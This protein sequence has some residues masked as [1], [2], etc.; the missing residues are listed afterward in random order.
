[1]ELERRGTQR[2]RRGNAEDVF[3]ELSETIIGCAVKVHSALGPGM[4][5]AAYE[6]C[7]C[8]ELARS[9]LSFRRQVPIPLVYEEVNLDCG[10]RL[11]LVV[12]H[13]AIV[14]LKSVD[15]LLPI[16]DCQLLTYLR[17]SGLHLGILL[18]FNVA[19]LR[20]GIRRKVLM[21]P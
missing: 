10:F 4:L 2:I 16:H 12:E 21:I 13:K 17:A 9:R 8:H 5:E 14:E 1:M 18:N 3:P 7:L 6:A 15:H 19:H 20:H 11:D